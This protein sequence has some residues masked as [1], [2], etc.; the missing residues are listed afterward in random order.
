M[1]GG[2]KKHFAI[3][4]AS[5]WYESDK[6]LMHEA[7]HIVGT[8]LNGVRLSLQNKVLRDPKRKAAVE[9]DNKWI[10]Q[11]ARVTEGEDYA[12]TIVFWLAARY[13]SKNFQKSHYK[14]LY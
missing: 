6:I 1:G 8:Y 10:T 2:F 9:A 14:N 13:K 3:Y 7:A 5:E 12:E 4:P 11:Y